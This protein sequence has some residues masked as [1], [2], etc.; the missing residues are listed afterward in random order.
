MHSLGIAKR[1][2]ESFS[3]F[4]RRFREEGKAIQPKYALR[5][6]NLLCFRYGSYLQRQ[7][8]RD[9]PRPALTTNMLKTDMK[10]GKDFAGI[11]LCLIL[12]LLSDAGRTVLNKY[13][14]I[15]EKN[16]NE[17]IETLELVI[18][19]EQFLKHCGLKKVNLPRLPKLIHQ[20]ITKICTNCPRLNRI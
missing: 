12:A 2:V 16:I 14:N 7:S 8:D 3:F 4:V 1:A 19:M 15:K 13:C 18:C 9:F 6:M 5:T 10:E 11:I 20:F 17:L